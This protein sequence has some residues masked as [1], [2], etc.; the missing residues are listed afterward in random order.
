MR[1][2]MFTGKYDQ[3]R[4]GT[5]ETESVEIDGGSAFLRVLFEESG[6]CTYSYSLDG[7]QYTT[8]GKTVSVAP[9]V[10]IGAKVGLFAVNPDIS[11]SG[12]CAD[13]DWFRFE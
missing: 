5:E 9:G 2:D 6:A 11:E 4:D 10:W 12:G 7:E 13:F 1:L 3:A 8:I